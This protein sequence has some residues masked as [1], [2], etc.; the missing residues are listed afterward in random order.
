[1][2]NLSDKLTAVERLELYLHF[3]KN[4]TQYSKK[5]REELEKYFDDG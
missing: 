2:I 4:K 3:I 5:E 1:M